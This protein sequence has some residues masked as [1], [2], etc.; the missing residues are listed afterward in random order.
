MIDTGKIEK[1]PRTVGRPRNED[2]DDAI[3][4]STLELLEERGYHGLSLAAVAARA[5]TSTPAIYRRWSSKADLVMHAAFRTEGNDVI[6]ETG[7]LDRDVR[8][9]IRWTLEKLGNPLG[10]AALAGL[11]GE[12]AADSPN[13][14]GQ[15]SGLWRA[16]TAHLDR[17]KA[18]GAVRADLDPSMFIALLAGP[19]MLAGTALG[20]SADDDSWVDRL[21]EPLLMYILPPG[22]N[23]TKD[24][25]E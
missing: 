18:R 7:D 25:A 13:R 8:T 19:A 15:M 16:Q 3:V 21:A 24:H 1:A 12:P 20:V 17:M 10:R 2:L 22:G 14:L 23:Q 4:Q 9:M 6:A 5:G 11:L